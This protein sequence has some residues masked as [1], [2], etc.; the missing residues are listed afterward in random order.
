MTYTA[1]K[2]QQVKLIAKHFQ[3]KF[4]KFRPPLPEVPP[5]LMMTPFASGE[6]KAAIKQL[7]NNKSAGG[8]KY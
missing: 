2:K 3:K 1:N 6:V 7:Q 4:N 8:K 5:E